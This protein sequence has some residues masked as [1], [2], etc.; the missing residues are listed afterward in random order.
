MSTGNIGGICEK[1]QIPAWIFSVG[2][3]R[4]TW[5]NRLGLEHWKADS[6][7]ELRARRFGDDMSES[8]RARLNQYL[9]DCIKHQD[10]IFDEWTVY[11]GGKPTTLKMAFSTCVEDES[12]D[13][14]LI[15]VIGED[16]QADSGSLY[17][18]QALMHTSSLISI[19]DEKRSL[20]YANPAS[21]AIFTSPDLQMED[22][23]IDKSELEAILPR[24]QVNKCSKL[25]AKVNTT[26]GARWHAMRVQKCLDPVTGSSTILISATDVTEERAAKLELVRQA[27]ADALT[28]LL[29][30][31][32]F[33]QKVNS[34]I[35]SNLSEP[36]AL[37]FI[38]I[39][40]FKLVNDS[41]GHRIGD[42]LLKRIAEILKAWVPDTDTIARLSGDEFAIASNY[43]DLEKI[44]EEVSQLQKILIDPVVV[45]HHK[46]RVSL[47][48]GVSRYP[49]DG[50]SADDLLQ[51]AD[52][53]KQS[54]RKS[55]LPY[56]CF[57]F[58]L[59]K[60]RR[61]RVEIEADLI[62]AL[63]QNEFVLHYQP[64]IDAV[65]QTVSGVEALVRW[66]H[67]HKGRISP[68]D[69]IPVAEETG[70]IVDIGEWVLRKAVA[71]Q[72][73]WE[74]MGY[75]SGVAV[76]VSPLQFNSLE[77]PGLVHGILDESSCPANKLNLEITESTLG[78]DEALVLEIL[79][80]L[81]S[82]GIAISID[83]FGTGYSNLSNLQ[84]FPIDFL[85][86]DRS[87]VS[88][89]DHCALLST[90]LELGKL[91]RLKLVAEGV[92]TADQVN[93]LASRQCDQ[94]QGFFFS[95]PLPYDDLIE[96][97][98]VSAPYNQLRLV[99]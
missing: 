50:E 71:D 4:I 54:A 75:S 56:R 25:D 98:S 76:N 18:I 38:D 10:I 28:D 99:S 8:V 65:D 73:R 22:Y 32:A 86:I 62:N 59:G 30:R 53:A 31:H 58:A 1:F 20:I 92:E 61:E 7:D 51:N 17:G 63:E 67:P 81:S 36:F 34:R 5:A 64:K 29:N 93:W 41:V 47:S 46:L 23:F 72:V 24:L 26:V 79:S 12:A 82:Q 74:S 89:P 95:K 68:L 55:L 42:L 52:I 13:C 40:R 90:I 48:I 14:M 2:E 6:L 97:F 9:H 27:G 11:P 77:F 49:F 83:D 45:E 94:F 43:V 44:S 37:F 78:T 57:D 60:A 33:V 35:K 84:K 69:F 66:E 19:F 80:D 91:M 96:Y 85:K 39:D 70:L 87:F 15:Q 16:I 3:C 88:D 21:R